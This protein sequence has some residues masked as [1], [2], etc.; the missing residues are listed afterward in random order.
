VTPGDTC[1]T[2]NIDGLPVVLVLPERDV[3]L[4]VILACAI[5]GR[6]V[7]HPLPWYRARL[8]R[9]VP[10]KT[11]STKCGREYRRRWKG[12]RR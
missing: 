8:K 11:C 9:G 2:I 3:D 5:C 6:E 10:P 12:R 4:I 7:R 1:V